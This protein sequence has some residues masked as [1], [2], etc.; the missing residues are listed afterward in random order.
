MSVFAIA[1]TGTALNV[2]AAAALIGALSFSQEP[3][4]AS[5]SIASVC[6]PAGYFRSAPINGH[7]L[8]S[9]VGPFRAINGSRQPYSITSSARPSNIAG[10]SM[11]SAL[12]APTSLVVPFFIHIAGP[13]GQRRVTA[14]RACAR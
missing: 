2:P 6:L 1:L 10:I 11:P 7:H 14:G 5:G 4:S 12:A 8:T 3:M 9:P 13:Q